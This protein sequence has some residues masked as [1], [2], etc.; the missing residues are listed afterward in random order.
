[1]TMMDIV[2]IVILLL[3]ILLLLQP[4][5]QRWLPRQWHGVLQ[6]ILPPRSLKYEGTWRRKNSGMDAKK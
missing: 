1:M 6:R 3:L 4:F 5:Y 2:Q